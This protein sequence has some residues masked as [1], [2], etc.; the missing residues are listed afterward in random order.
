MK[1]LWM[2]QY[3]VFTDGWSMLGLYELPGL[4]SCFKEPLSISSWFKM[5]FCEDVRPGHIKWDSLLN[6]FI[7]SL[8][9]CLFYYNVSFSLSFLIGYFG[10]FKKSAFVLKAEGPYNCCWVFYLTFS[11]CA[12]FSQ[13]ERGAG[14]DHWF[15]KYCLFTA[16]LCFITAWWNNSSRR[17]GVMLLQGV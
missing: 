13:N 7:L 10:H 11:L 6:H 8:S 5:W 1:G 2:G 14:I 16:C 15:R 12:W 3:T 4:L 17:E 9:L